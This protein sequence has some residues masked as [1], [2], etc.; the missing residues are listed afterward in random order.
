[1]RPASGETVWYLSTGLSKPFF[2]ALLAAFAREIG[3]GHERHIVL[4]LDNAGWHGPEGLADIP[5]IADGFAGSERMVAIARASRRRS[6][7]SERCRRPRSRAMMG[8]TARLPLEN[9]PFGR[10][11]PAAIQ[12]GRLRR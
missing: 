6:C 10:A 12:A 4:L 2:E 3:A 11:P 7:R 8:S 9:P 5:Q 1:V